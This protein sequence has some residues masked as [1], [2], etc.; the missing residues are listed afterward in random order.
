MDSSVN[1]RRNGRAISKKSGEAFW[2]VSSVS[3]KTG[4]RLRCG[5][6][7]AGRYAS[8]RRFDVGYNPAKRMD[9]ADRL[10]S[11]RRLH[12]LDRRTSSWGTFVAFHDH[13]I[14]FWHFMIMKVFARIS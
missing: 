8:N 2:L 4:K 13:E 10:Y 9:R 14:A 7:L 12:T 5:P 3:R 11:A 6:K 1:S